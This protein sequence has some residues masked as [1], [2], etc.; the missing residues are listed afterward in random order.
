[1]VFSTKTTTILSKEASSAASSSFTLCRFLCIGFIGFGIVLGVSLGGYFS[2]K[3][4]EKLLDKFVDYI[5]YYKNN[6]DKLVN[7]YQNA[8][9]YFREYEI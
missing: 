6:V 9:D 1:M 2:H 4:C 5:D 8:A 3:F 7:S